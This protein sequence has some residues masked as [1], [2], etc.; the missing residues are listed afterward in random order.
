MECNN[1]KSKE[2]EVLYRLKDYEVLECGK[3][4]LRFSYPP[5]KHNYE[6]DYFTGEH[7]KYFS[8]CKKGYDENDLKIKNFKHGLKEI[9]KFAKKG[10]IFDLGCATGV[11]LDI[12][13]KNRWKSYGMDI[14]KYATSYA[15][16]TFKVH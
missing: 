3:C 12:C 5:L 15:K 9:E 1:C 16:K 13:K 14:S 10:K 4:R 6:K 8:S 7:K 2:V 11:F